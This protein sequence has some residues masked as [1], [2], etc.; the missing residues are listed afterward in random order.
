MHKEKI[1]DIVVLSRAE[2]GVP[3]EHELADYPPCMYRTWRFSKLW[4]PAD[5]SA[6]LYFMVAIYRSLLYH[7]CKRFKRLDGQS[8]LAKVSAIEGLSVFLM[9][10]L[11]AHTILTGERCWTLHSQPSNST[12]V[13]EQLN[14]RIVGP[15]KK[16]QE[17]ACIE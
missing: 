11:D 15:L 6:I 10:N 8:R 5:T 16:C 14:H 3:R 13:Y 7:T 1:A 2:H 17:V 9:D 12:S 4:L